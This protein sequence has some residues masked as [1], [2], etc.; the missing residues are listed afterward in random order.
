MIP[1]SV[2]IWIIA[3]TYIL[4]VCVGELETNAE[5]PYHLME[6]THGPISQIKDLLPRKID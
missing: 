3:H 5:D 4:Q 1:I 2:H 6:F